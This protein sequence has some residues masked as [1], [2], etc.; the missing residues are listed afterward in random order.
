MKKGLKHTCPKPPL[1]Y[2]IVMYVR[3]LLILLLHCKKKFVRFLPMGSMPKRQRRRDRPGACRD[4]AESCGDWPDAY[5][6]TAE[7]CRGMPG[8]CRGGPERWQRES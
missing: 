7:T 5:K 2:C 1:H 6:D 4:A 8:A 3:Y